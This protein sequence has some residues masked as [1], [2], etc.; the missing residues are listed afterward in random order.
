MMPE[1]DV[2]AKIAGFVLP[3]GFDTFAVAI[4]LG[5]RNVKPFRPTITF[6]LFEVLMP[7]IGVAIGAAAGR[8]AVRPAAYFGAALVA[9]V[10]LHAIWEAFGHAPDDESPTFSTSRGIVLA[11]LGIS[12]DEIAIGFPLGT[13]HL[14]IVIVLTAIGLQTALVTASGIIIGR[15]IGESLGRRAAKA[16][17]TVAGSAFILL[18][19]YLAIEATR[20]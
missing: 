19:G 18:A 5:M 11:G 16:A 13:L 2:V 1:A 8:W 6:T 14:P 17:T 3:L 20:R 7:L 12:A 15:S 4:A 10:G 9:A